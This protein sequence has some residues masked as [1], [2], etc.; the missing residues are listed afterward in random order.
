M[1]AKI[2]TNK[3]GG[4]GGNFGRLAGY[5][6]DLERKAQEAGT[7][8]AQDQAQ[9]EAFAALGGYIADLG[10]GGRDGGIKVSKTRVTNCQTADVSKAIAVVQATQAKN[11]RAKQRD[12]HLVV[13]FPEGEVPSY[14]VLKNIEDELVK[15]LG[16]E[17][18][19]RVS[20]VH[21]DTDNLHLHIGINLVHPDT[22]KVKHPF[23]SERKLMAKCEELEIKHGLIR[24]NHGL[25]IEER[26]KAEVR[27]RAGD[28]EAHTRL[29]SFIRW[30]RETARTSLVE[31]RDGG[32]GWATFHVVAGRFGLVAKRQG[33]GL[34]FVHAENERLAVKASDI[35]RGLSLKALTAAFGPYEAPTEMPSRPQ[36]AV[37]NTVDMPDAPSTTPPQQ[38]SGRGDDDQP[39]HEAA[40]SAGR[41]GGAAH[42]GDAPQ[43]FELPED[44][45]S[46]GEQPT[47]TAEQMQ[48]AGM[49][50]VDAA[51]I[52]EGIGRMKAVWTLS[53]M[54]REIIHQ[55]AAT[56]LND[57]EPVMNKLLD[58]IA[59]SPDLV[60][61][62]RGEEEPLYC[63]RP[64]VRLEQRMLKAAERL[65]GRPGHGL[66]A[67]VVNRVLADIEDERRAAGKPVALSAEQRAAVLHSTADGDLKLVLGLPGTGKSMM[68]GD[69]RRVWEAQ[70][71]RVE[72]AALS[73]I[74]AENLTKEAQIPAT[75][76]AGLLHR[77]EGIH[78]LQDFLE[79]GELTETV[80]A[81]LIRSANWL[82][83]HGEPA[84]AREAA[85]VRAEL[86]AG[87]LT[88]TGRDW[89][90]ETVQR[91]LD[92][93]SLSERTVLVVDEAGMVASGQMA[94]ILEHVEA[95]GAKLVL[96][97]D[98]NQ[99]QA[100]EAG[101]PF[102]AFCERMPYASLTDVRRQRHAWQRAATIDLAEKRVAEGILSYDTHGAVHAGIAFDEERFVAGVERRL[103]APLEAA[104]RRRVA[105][106]AQYAEARN[107]AGAL[108]ALITSKDIDVDLVDELNGLFKDWQEQRD[109]MA[110]TIGA[111]LEAY[112][113]WLARFGVHG[114]GLAADIAYAQGE[115]R[116]AA[117]AMAVSEAKRLGILD[118]A[119]RCPPDQRLRADFR[120]GAKQALIAAWSQ[121]ASDKSTII[122]A[123]SR[124]DVEDLNAAAREVVRAAG[125]LQGEDVM[126]AVKD[127]SRAFAAGDRILFLAPD[128][129]LGVKNGTFGTIEAIRAEEG[130]LPTITARLADGRVVEVD[131]KR[132]NS[133]DLGYA[134][135]V[136]KSQGV[137]V[138]HTFFLATSNID[139]HLALVGM[140]RHRDSLSVYLG[141]GD[142]AAAMV[143]AQTASRARSQNTT[144]DYDVPD[145]AGVEPPPARHRQRYRAEARGAAKEGRDS[146]WA[147]YQ[148]AHQAT[149]DARAAALAQVRQ[150]YR[151][152]HDEL[153]AWYKSSKDALY[154]GLLGSIIPD[155]RGHVREFTQIRDERRALAR[156]Q[157]QAALQAVRE[158][159]GAPSWRQWLQTQADAGNS[160]A[161]RS[162]RR[163]ATTREQFHGKLAA[164]ISGEAAADVVLTSR[165]PIATKDGQL[166]YR[167]PDGTVVVKVD[168][169]RVQA[170]QP[171]Q[172]GAIL[173]L[174]VAKDTF[175]DQILTVQGPDNFRQ[176]V[177]EHAGRI[178]AAI[179]FADPSME[180]VRIAARNENLVPPLVTP[181][182]QA[183]KL[184]RTTLTGGISTLRYENAPAVMR[185]Q[186]TFL[187]VKDGPE[188]GLLW[189]RGG[190]VFIQPANSVNEAASRGLQQG[191]TVTF[192]HGEIVADRNIDDSLSH[193]R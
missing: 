12:M 78:S 38:V 130:Q 123:H 153:N 63:H 66:A 43:W 152:Y 121:S 182:A 192:K 32:Q 131:S 162:L 117:M 79:T 11:T 155:R 49:G 105:V 36:P 86:Q 185:G 90:L 29:D 51:A 85:E 34:V 31:A 5:I 13:S 55:L 166:L 26:S 89:V 3:G 15:T 172:A 30:T 154:Q 69:A 191:D 136:H 179:H 186:Y 190:V 73:G 156:Q 134:T 161:L 157:E 104:D 64:F 111:D 173:A 142:A 25:T 163:Q 84:A 151:D 82:E 184:G 56:G 17:E 122:L 124:A 183:V 9:L 180:R 169:H 50:R 146:L 37:A 114:E 126:I 8:P 6:G 158:R 97:G 187:G 48:F 93:S 170:S 10:N 145:M 150:T 54:R 92:R 68:L 135:T 71:F 7:T 47:M 99:L 107:A 137:T 72:G 24:T 59:L 129:E 77:L 19:Q 167:M 120:T 171:T 14:R 16:L 88:P 139:R 118:I 91:R 189:Q 174:E 100:I 193:G 133:F 75:T 108:W 147:Q 168:E 144:L 52:L 95:S 28:M 67:D 57:I 115:R 116:A 39:A 27:G 132:Y 70:G 46:A 149:I 102:R 175:K 164:A 20:A 23:Q 21:V 143:F 18:H 165:R 96:V 94:A 61:I 22:Y 60:T 159:F 1:I 160:A 148:A 177:A 65:G 109:D 33:A 188:G 125:R 87:R 110:L 98:H 80:T 101:A 138:D 53:D 106:I 81:D 128:T 83:T 181:N 127:G 76:V 178:G 113:P 74:A 176:W 119:E 2:I 58:Q 44:S 103:G 4:K 45:P 62:E 112:K 141:A 140:T 35:D 42:P 40:R 41:D